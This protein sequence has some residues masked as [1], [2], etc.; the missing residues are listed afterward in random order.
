MRWTTAKRAA[1]VGKRFLASQMDRFPTGAARF[2]ENPLI[3]LLAR[4]LSRWFRKRR[5][6]LLTKTRRRFESATAKAMGHPP[7]EPRIRAKATLRLHPVT[8]IVSSVRHVSNLDA[9]LVW[10]HPQ[11]ARRFI[12]PFRQA[13][14]RGHLGPSM[15]ATSRESATRFRCRL[16]ALARVARWVEL[17]VWPRI[18][19]GDSDNSR[20]V[21]A[22]IPN[23]IR[24]EGVTT[25]EFGYRGA[26]V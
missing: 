17:V 20:A 4:V 1:P 21:R 3:H 15:I 9:Q 8:V 5:S 14:P 6:T 13:W 23:V 24:V 7:R 26:C 2:I 25:Q 22:S 18:P 10:P 12:V 11:G 16:Q 19:S